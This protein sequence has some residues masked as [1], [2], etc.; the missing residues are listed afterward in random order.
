M[1]AERI[2]AGEK[3]LSCLAHHGI[4]RADR[5]GRRGGTHGE[6][7]LSR[8]AVILLCLLVTNGCDPLL[9]AA[10]P[11]AVA[12]YSL[13]RMTGSILRDYPY[14]LAEVNQAA[15][16]TCRNLCMEILK[17][18]IYARRGKIIGFDVNGDDFSISFFQVH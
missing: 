14:N 16:N 13:E 17:R 11:V 7:M 6:E 3:G 1:E 4:K 2:L 18:Q 5:S 9:I 8:F 12:W 10:I 15:Q